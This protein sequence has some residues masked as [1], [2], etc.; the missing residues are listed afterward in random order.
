MLALLGACEL[1]KKGGGGPTTATWCVA[2]VT[3]LLAERGGCSCG[4]LMEVIT[5]TLCS[6][7]LSRTSRAFTFASFCCAVTT[8]ET[9]GGGGGETGALVTLV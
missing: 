4:V 6:E 3:I 1:S 7:A 9:G 2:S 5:S 8:C